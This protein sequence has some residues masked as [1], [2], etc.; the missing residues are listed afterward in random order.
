MSKAKELEYLQCCFIILLTL[1]RVVI[2]AQKF[3]STSLLIQKS[4]QL[5]IL[6]R[7]EMQIIPGV[8]VVVFFSFIFFLY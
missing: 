6:D 2:L 4:P 1:L 7:S 8:R 5:G 3:H